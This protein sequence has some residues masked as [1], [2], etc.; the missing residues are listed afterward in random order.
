MKSAEC[1]GSFLE[2]GTRYVA[3]CESDVPLHTH[4]PYISGTSLEK[5]MLAPAVV[6][7]GDISLVVAEQVD[8]LV[9]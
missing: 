3:D 9:C 8:E 2:V 5:G 1:V 4:L 7:N 6:K